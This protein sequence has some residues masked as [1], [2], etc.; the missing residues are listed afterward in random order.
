MYEYEEKRHAAVFSHIGLHCVEAETGKLL[1]LYEWQELYSGRHIPDPLI[2]DNKAFITDFSFKGVEFECVLLDIE[3][4]EPKVIWENQNLW[5]EI[6]SPVMVDG[7]IYGS[8]GGPD[9]G[10]T[11]LRCL[12][13]KTGKLMWE[14]ILGKEMISLIASD[15]KLIILEDI[16]TLRIAEATPKAYKEIYSCNLPSESRI[17]KW[18]TPPVLYKSRIYCRDYTGDLVCIDVSNDS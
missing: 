10:S 11:S 17:H 6:S 4:A 15:G 14:K 13:V 2:F 8:H 9:M 5:S 3:G 12:D 7:Y 16:G 1:W 18:F